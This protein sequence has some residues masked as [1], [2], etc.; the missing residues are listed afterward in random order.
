MLHQVACVHSIGFNGI[1]KKLKVM[2][3]THFLLNVFCLKTVLTWWFWVNNFDCP[4]AHR[5][6]QSSLKICPGKIYTLGKSARSGFQAL[7]KKLLREEGVRT[8]VMIS[9]QDKFIAIDW[10]DE[11]YIW[12]IGWIRDIPGVV[13][14]HRNFLIALFPRSYS[15]MKLDFKMEC[16]NEILCCLA[17]SWNSSYIISFR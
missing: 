17:C 15:Y 10:F 13:E 14:S 7:K 8:P 1:Y 9:P 4:L 11:D 3:P 6:A 2:P 12:D 5:C 16:S